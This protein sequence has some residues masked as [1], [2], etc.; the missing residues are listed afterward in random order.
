M[1]ISILIPTYNE[2]NTLIK[3]IDK[4]LNNRKYDLE[5]IIIDDGST[6]NTLEILKRKYSVN[7]KIKIIENKINFGKGYSIRKGI[8]VSTG[9]IILI[10]DA[11]LEYDPSEHNRLLDPIANNLADVVYGSRFVGS[12]PHRAIYFFNRVANLLLTTLSNVLTNLNLTDMETG[13]KAFNSEILKSISLK[14]NGFGIEPEL[15]V[16]LAKKKARFIEVGVSYFGRSYEEGKK[17]RAVHF[18]E[19]IFVLLKKRIFS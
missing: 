9:E 3:I 12:D 4:T 17:I 16:M 19:A 8:E 15:T 13:F 6:D 1:K 2:E 18:F 5:V 14:E 7:K 11:D 10:Q